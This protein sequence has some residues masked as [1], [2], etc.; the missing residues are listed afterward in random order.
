[1][2]FPAADVIEPAP[3][4]PSRPTT[5]TDRGGTILLVEDERPVREVAKRMLER[6]GFAVLEARHALDALEIWR[7]RM[8]GIDAILTDLRM[9]GMGGREFVAVVRHDRPHLPVVFMSGYSG[10]GAD[11]ALGPLDAF[12]EKP[13]TTETLVAALAR[14]RS[15]AAR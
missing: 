5:T 13:F 1:M 11:L 9:P 4:E 6:A 14:V 7:T 12:V 15:G 8:D 10:E 3:T 2:H